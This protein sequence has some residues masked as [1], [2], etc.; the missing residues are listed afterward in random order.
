MGLRD[1]MGQSELRDLQV[2]QAKRAM[3]EEDAYRAAAQEAG[4]DML[5]LGDLLMAKG[6]PGKA[7]AVRKAV[8]DQQKAE[9]ELGKTRAET[10]VK[11]LEAKRDALAGV[12][13][14]AG[15]DRWLELVARIDG[16]DVVSKL[17]AQY[18]PQW[19]QAN[20]LRASDVVQNAREAL[21]RAVTVRGQ[22]LSAETSRRGQDIAAQTAREGHALTRRGQDLTD[23]RARETI[24]RERWQY[25]AQRGGMVNL[26]TQEFRP[27]TEGGVP[28]QT[29]YDKEVGEKQRTLDAYIAARDG[30]MSALKESVT[31]PVMGR[32]TPITA[33]QQTAEGGVAAMAPV[34]K[35]LFRS[36]GEGVFTDRD[37]QLLLDMVPKRTDRLEA[38]AAKMANIDRIVAAKLGRSVPTR[39]PAGQPARGQINP[40]SLSNDELLR[41]LNR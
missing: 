38:A 1:L 26:D 35:Q 7:M 40:A 19:Q 14:Q 8:A 24:A 20:I 22:D 12:R 21:N 36:A 33:A 34:L 27:V 32:I 41:E 39:P 29:K 37:Q 18:N 13:D 5:R 23:A 28:V 30:L 9:A 4:G 17:P 25:D 11:N 3:E 15:Y 16:P 2:A 6:A 31:G 10:L